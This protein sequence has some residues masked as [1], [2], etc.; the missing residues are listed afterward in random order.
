MQN[1]SALYRQILSQDNHWFETKVRIN[2][3]DYGESMLMGVS[4]TS[5]MFSGNP[6]VGRAISGEISLSMIAPSNTIPRMAR[7]EPFV[8]VCAKMATA[9]D[10]SMQNDIVTFGSSFSQTDGIIDLGTSAVLSNDIV[11][12][13]SSYSTVSSE[14]LPMGVYYIDTRETTKNGDGLNILTLHGYDAML[15]A[16][17]DFAGTSLDFPAIDTDIVAEIAST[18]G[19]QVDDRTYDLMT[20]EYTMPLPSGYSLREILGYIASMYV[21]SFIMSETGELRLVSI[22]ELPPE[23]NYLIDNAGDAITFGGDRIL[24]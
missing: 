16:E 7:I 4:T 3:I 9:P 12:F 5:S 18:M 21:G 10:V 14:W 19:V 2:G 17:Q 6:E 13:R 1:T 22:L 11:Y 20:D 23:T 8:R 15:F 24:V